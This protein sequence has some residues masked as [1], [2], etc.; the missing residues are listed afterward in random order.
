MTCAW[1]GGF[2]ENV[3][4]VDSP[5]LVHREIGACWRGGFHAYKH[6]GQQPA[7]AAADRAFKVQVELE[8]GIVA[9]CYPWDIPR[10]ARR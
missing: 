8:P 7:V 5:I 1:C 3:G 10:G 9:L 2:A 4:T 6:R